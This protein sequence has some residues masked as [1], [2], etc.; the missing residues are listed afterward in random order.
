MVYPR[1]TSLWS[2]ASG[3]WLG[4]DGNACEGYGFKILNCHPFT[5]QPNQTHSIDIAFTPDFT[6]SKV[7][8]TLLLTDATGNVSYYVKRDQIKL[9]K[10]FN[11]FNRSVGELFN[12]HVCFDFYFI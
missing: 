7:R 1:Q 5:L 9:S 3:M 4:T 6:L 8:S 2:W 10:Y 12:N 11:I